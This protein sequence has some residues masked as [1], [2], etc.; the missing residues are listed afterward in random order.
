MV[1]DSMLLGSSRFTPFKQQAFIGIDD[2]WRYLKNSERNGSVAMSMCTPFE[3]ASLDSRFEDKLGISV[4][5]ILLSE[6]NVEWYKSI[7]S[8]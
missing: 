2:G 6:L 3:D 5:E 7:T 8:M 1:N 4:D